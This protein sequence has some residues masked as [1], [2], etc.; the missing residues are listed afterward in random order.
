MGEIAEAIVNGDLCE[1]CGSWI[2][3]GD[4]YPRNCGCDS[5]A[6]A[7][8]PAPKPFKCPKCGKS[9]EKKVGRTDHF[10]NHHRSEVNKLVEGYL[11]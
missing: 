7:A 2:G 5:G 6:R 4:G 8:A 3:P 9:F 1:Q 11:E 10:I